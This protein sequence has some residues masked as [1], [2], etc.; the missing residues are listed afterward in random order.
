MKK[1]PLIKPEINASKLCQAVRKI[2]KTG[3]LT[4][5]EYI[6]TFQDSLARYLR[7]KH[8]FAVSSCT[9]ALHLALLAANVKEGDEVLVSD[10]SFPASANVI[11][12]TGAKPVFVD[13]DLE[14]FCLNIDDLKAKINMHAKK[15]KAIMIVHAFGYP[16]NMSEIMKIAR[17]NKLVVI[18][19]AACAIGSKHKSKYCG[20]WGDLGCFSFHPR[21]LLTTGE[22]GAVVTNNPKLAE[23]IEI[24]R[25][26][27]GIYTKKGW[28]FVE[29]GFNYRL[30][31]LQAAL[32]VEQLKTLGQTIKHRQKLAR[33][34]IQKLKK[35][36][37]IVCPTEPRDGNFNFQSFVIL[38]PENIDRD[39]L[40]DFLKKQNIETTLG[41]YAMHL[42]KA[43]QEY[44]PSSC[45]N[46]RY[47]Y[48][49]SLT[50]PL[51]EK[52]NQA[53]MNYVV[54]N[55]KDYLEKFQDHD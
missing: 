39:D 23:R 40:V 10:F 49:H 16:A 38:L 51:Y 33:K 11:V 12:H 45:K 30:S 19:D 18:E 26:H 28:E 47:A 48:K 8:I 1:I 29:A 6:Q 20:T 25:N 22:G 4:K 7:V 37:D 21:K 50:L 15:V 2:A 24:L 9:A 36:K 52:M 46:S 35:V 13:I 5:G 41:T 31:E 42:Q 44:K 17:K 55:L 3:M 34:Y 27:G 53:Q 32:G 43:F 54:K 14:T